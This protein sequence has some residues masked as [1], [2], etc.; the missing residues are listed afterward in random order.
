MSEYRKK[1]IEVALPL[2][3]VNDAS[4]YDKMPGIGPHPKGIHHW[5]A[6]LP[7]PA[8]R[9]VLFSSVVDDPSAHPERFPT[10][11]AQK[12]ERERLFSMIRQLLQKKMHEHPEAYAN[13]WAEMQRHAD[14]RLPAVLDPFTGGGSIPLE[15]A[16]LGLEAN[17]ADLNPVA[18]LLNKCNLEIVPRWLNQL[19]V[20]PQSR[21]D[22]LR[23][24]EWHGA[25]GL[26]DDIR[27]YA[28]AVREQAIKKIGHLYPTVT[29]PKEY[30]GREAPVVVWL[31]ARTVAS[32]NPTAGGVHVPLVASFWLSSKKGNLAWMEPIVNK[33]DNSWRFDICTGEPSDRSSVRRG[34]KLGRGAFRC[35]LTG[36]PI[37]YSYLRDQASVGRLGRALL[38]IVADI[39]RGKAYVPATPEQ[40]TLGTTDLAEWRPDEPVTTPCHD[41]DRLPM[42]GMPTWADAFAPRQ[43]TAMVTL[44]DA[45][46]AVRSDI[47][48]DAKTAG[49]NAADTEEYARAICS[50]LALALDRCAD[51]GN[52]IC[53]WSPTN[54]KVMHLFG[55][56]AIPMVWDFAEANTLGDSVGAWSTC[57][58]YV[59]ACTEVLGKTPTQLGRARQIDAATSWD[60]L[61]G[62]LVSTDPPYYDNIGYAA[63]SD[64]FYV[65]LRRTVGDLYPDLFGTILVPK[66]PELIAA[67]E[68]FEGDKAKAKEHFEAGFRRAFSAL[69]EKMDPRFP[70]TIYY[71][72]KQEDEKSGGGDGEEHSLNGVDRTTG[73]ETLLDALLGSGFQI[74]ATWPVRASQKWR[75]LAMGTNALASY[76]ILACR[77]SQADAQQCSRREFMNE[78]KKELPAAL[79]HLQQGNIAPV[80]LAQAS[81]GPGMAVFSRYS[82]VLESSGKP[83]T[84]RTALALIN[85]MLDE[86]LT[87]Q[88]GEFDTDTRWAV[89]WFEQSGMDEDDFGVAETLSKAKNTAV[90][91]LVEAGIITARAGK[92]RL[93][94]RADMPADWN[95]ATDNRLTAWEVTQ[96]LI[97][98]LDQQGETGAADLLR[99]LGGDYGEK[100]R[101]LAYRLYSIC[102]RQK[103]ANEALAY[104]SLVIAWP[105]ISKL[106]RKAPAGGG[107]T[108]TLFE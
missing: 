91:G 62:L 33:D 30:G 32:P 84:V 31:W 87:E 14:G 51:F 88:E 1:L 9:V 15:A 21:D 3:E 6:R 69:R 24:P 4:A 90:N 105:E 44:S 71:A 19:P 73:W 7:L 28:R 8:A 52:S 85:Q 41:V 81:I 35:L 93:I 79:K 49:L 66:E 23:A 104:N 29:L 38:C 45:I 72:F 61:R 98:A 57:S 68:R 92:V 5:W 17:A 43:L 39:G 74:T 54:H 100:A 58:D 37:E 22:T 56:Q 99:K 77:P 82:V 94:P 10:E 75:M 11:D 42:Y 64:F 108:G 20:N 13:A 80:D 2:S 89:A 107:D 102:E 78:L 101:D 36:Q 59:A 65:W 26:A 86:V 18:V 106:A 76:I 67:P 53:T 83:M 34:T 55:R 48:Q 27:Y 46:R 16:R 95:P 47:L 63:L 70:L 103:W 12:R 50:F 96:H 40:E 25:R 60:E 97:R